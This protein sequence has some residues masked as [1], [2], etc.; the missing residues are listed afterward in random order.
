MLKKYYIFIISILLNVLSFGTISLSSNSRINN[1]EVN[2]WYVNDKTIYVDLS[3]NTKFKEEGA[4]PTLVYKDTTTHEVE[5]TLIND[6]LYKTK[7][8]IPYTIFTNQD[9]GFEIHSF[10]SSIDDYLSIFIS[11]GEDNP[12]LNKEYNYLC[13]DEYT[14]NSKQEI[15]G[16]GYYGERIKNPG[17]TYKTQRVWLNNTYPNFYDNDDWGTPRKNVIGYI[18][19]LSKAFILIEMEQVLNLSTNETYYYA[20]IPYTVSSMS[21]L[22]ISQKE[23]H[24]YLIYDMAE[25]PNISYGSCY[26]ADLN[27]T[28]FSVLTGS[29]NSASATILKYVCEAYLTYGKADSNGSTSFTVSNL[30][31][32]WFKNKSATINDL[33]KEILMDYSGYSQNGNS[34]ENLIKDT[35]YS[36][37]EKWKTMC[38]QAGIDPNTGEFRGFNLSFFSSDL[39]KLLLVVGGVT[40]I[41]ILIFI[42]YALNK[43]HKENIDED[44]N[45][46]IES[47]KLFLFF[48]RL[49]DIIFSL[50]MIII[51]TILLWWWI[52]IV[53]MIITKGH[54]VFAPKR[55]GK[56]KKIFKMFKFRSMKVD[57][58]IIP[59][60]EMSDNDRDKYE[61]KFGR[62]L[63]VTSIDETL[64]FINVFIGNMSFVGPRPGASEHEDILIEARDKYKPSAFDV[65]PGITGYS[66]VYMKRQHDVMSKAWFDSEYVKKMSVI[67]DTKI[68]L[69]TFLFIKGK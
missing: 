11:G 55:V 24:S 56:H 66:Q 58:P 47:K 21:F 27:N 18:D 12:L 7:E 3:L 6:Y 32:T 42:I 65:K 49:F 53:N 33:K 68:M 44:D 22:S 69:H 67:L 61:T 50:I 39:F 45:Y 9:Y 35:P 10:D 64:Q 13:L 43:A 19:D 48:K 63:R 62:F 26:F 57:A 25:I 15:K 28:E 38:S 41:V 16:Y 40:L 52:F 37:N 46:Y 20:D 14:A 2:A 34:Y 31:N 5:L 8:V 23:G 4:N 51:S 54:P 29:V 30:F 59:P 36:V 17:A 60:Y 1:N